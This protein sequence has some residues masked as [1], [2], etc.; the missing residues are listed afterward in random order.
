MHAISGEHGRPSC[1]N[2]CSTTGTFDS[3]QSSQTVR[4]LSPLNMIFHVFLTTR[5]NDIMALKCSYVNGLVVSADSEDFKID[6]SAEYNE[7]R[8]KPG[9]F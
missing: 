9:G 2:T 5:R 3:L 8:C 1:M 7:R 4:I 6:H